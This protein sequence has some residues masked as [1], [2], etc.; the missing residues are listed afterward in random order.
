[1]KDFSSVIKIDHGIRDGAENMKQKKTM[2]TDLVSVRK[3]G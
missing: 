2:Q 1:M 3:L